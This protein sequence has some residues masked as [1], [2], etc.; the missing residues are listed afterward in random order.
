MRKRQQPNFSIKDKMIQ[1]FVN[2]NVNTQRAPPWHLHSV[3]LNDKYEPNH[4]HLSS[5][6]SQPRIWKHKSLNKCLQDIN[7]HHCIWHSHSLLTLP[8]FAPFSKNWVPSQRVS[9]TYLRSPTKWLCYFI[10]KSSICIRIYQLTDEHTILYEKR[11]F[12]YKI[13]RSFNF[14]YLHGHAILYEK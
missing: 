5:T 14:F 2:H 4:F 9:D 1:I 3:F 11:T 10:W 12:S 13:T 7:H 6:R 8:S